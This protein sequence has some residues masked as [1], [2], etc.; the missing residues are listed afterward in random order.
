MYLN[1]NLQEIAKQ[2]F[3]EREKIKF[4]LP[5]KL[6][7]QEFIIDLISLLFPRYG[8]M[9][10]DNLNEVEI[11][12]LQLYNKLSKLLKFLY[13]S[14]DESIKFI[15]NEFFN[16]ILEIRNTLLLD[17]EVIAR[18]D[19]AAESIDE[20][21]LT[22]PGF[23]AIA[24]Y[25]FAHKFYKLN[26][27]IFPRL[28]TEFAHQLT[29]IDIHPGAEIGKSFFID[30]GTGIVIGET[31][32]IGDN[33]KIYQGVTLGALSVRKTLSKIKRH[34]TIEDNVIIYSGST[35]LGGKTV[36]GRDS[37]IGG[38]TWI[39]ESIPPNSIVYNKNE[40]KLRNFNELDN[41]L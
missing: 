13:P 34:P 37:V 36:I 16:E 8:K 24:V 33:V 18:E 14:N 22:Y 38:N 5:S 10:I 7:S 39:T 31:T 20:V 41:E 35:I 27:P 26:V 3:Y 19:P 9:N 17:A 23:F 30:H 15:I 32:V 29:G 4:N 1:I 25:R 11:E 12:I 2:I 21:I 40:F 28:L 6:D